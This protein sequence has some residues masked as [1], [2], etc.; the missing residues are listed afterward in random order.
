MECGARL[1]DP[2]SAYLYILVLK[3]LLI[4]TKCHRNIHGIETFKP[5]YLYTAYADDTIFLKKDVSSVK[6]VLS[7]FD[8]FSRFSGL[9]PNV[10]KYVMAGIGVLKNVNVALCGMKNVDLTKETIKI[11]DVHI[12]DNKKLQDDLNYPDSIA[13]FINYDSKFGN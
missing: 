11:L 9:R 12:S 7:F 2:I 5:A 13:S 10:S 6:I 3:T 8:S 4:L 1:F